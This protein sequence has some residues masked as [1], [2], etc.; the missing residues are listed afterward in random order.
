MCTK[1]FILTICAAVLFPSLALADGAMV[2]PAN[3]TATESGQT[4]VLF[5]E[6]AT[7]TET[8]AVQTKYTSDAKDFVW[9]IPT[10]AQP[11]IQRASK[12]IFTKL[13][14][15][16]SYSYTSFSSSLSLGST[17]ASLDNAQSTVTVVAEQSV[18]YYDAAV[19]TATNAT[20]LVQ[21][22][23]DHG[24]AFQDKYKY[25]LEDYL[26]NGWYFTALRIDQSALD[27]LKTGKKAQSLTPIQLTFSASHLVYPLRISSISAT[28]SSQSV[29]L[30]VIDD[31][32]LQTTNFSTSYSNKI[33]RADI[34]AWGT[35]TDGNAWVE[36]QQNSY[37]LTKLYSNVSA[38]RMTDDV[39][40]SDAK[41]NKTVGVSPNWNWDAEAWANCILFTILA[42]TVGFA[43]T[44]LSPFGVGYLIATSVRIWSHRRGWLIAGAIVQWCSYVT[45]VAVYTLL[46]V[47]YWKDLIHNFQPPR[48]SSYR[49]DEIG[50]TVGIMIIGFGLPVIMLGLNCVTAKLRRQVHGLR[51]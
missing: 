5:Y 31:H 50:L 36:P 39:F 3:Y 15:L 14:A 24:Y 22:F 33:S 49:P 27:T 44:L 11:T 45:I 25:I 47:V 41:D 6:A 18:D 1:H 38:A 2:T 16:T 8:L 26:S 9:I 37:Y 46:L 51:N 29:T 28:T 32:K 42:I 21:W 17:G 43:L 10:P 20:D 19:L 48:Y 35:D 40:F 12:T 34:T 30:Y 13:A 7:Q 4:A 23:N